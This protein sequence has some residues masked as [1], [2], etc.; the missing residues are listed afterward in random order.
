MD[1]LILAVVCGGDSPEA[2][3]SEMGARNIISLLDKNRYEPYLVNISQKGW[4]VEVEGNQT[5]IEVDKN[6]FSFTLNG[7][8][9]QFAYAYI[10]I[11]GTPGENGILQSY[12]ELLPMP[13]STCG[14]ESS[15]ITFNKKVCKNTLVDSNINLAKDVYITKDKFVGDTFCQ[16]DIDDIAEKLKLP[17]FVKPVD[18]G[19][20]FGVSKVK[21]AEDMV[22]ALDEAFAHSSKVIIEEFLDGREFAQGVYSLDGEIYT[23]PLTEV[24]SKR[25]FFDYEAKYEGLSTEVTPANV[26]KSIAKEISESAKR[27]YTEL[28]CRGCVRIDFILVGD[29]PYMVEVNT[30][31]GMSSASIIPQQIRAAGFKESDFLALIIDDTLTNYLSEKLF[32]NEEE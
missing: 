24:I 10:N 1:K 11:H 7:E 17:L 23:L 13:Y 21:K 32:D 20:S 19:S 3:I 14:V 29:T 9:H 18:S 2:G 31:P 30:T 12:F 27:I 15:M 26:D 6:N 28:E 25:E 16:K 22:S 4:F 8:K 5:P